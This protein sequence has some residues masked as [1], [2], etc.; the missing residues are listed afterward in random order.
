MFKNTLIKTKI[1]FLVG[2]AI[3]LSS[4][5]AELI[6]IYSIK[7]V[8]KQRIEKYRVDAYKEAKSN[9]EK[10]SAI[11]LSVVNYYYNQSDKDRM[12]DA[13]KDY[14]DEQSDYLF[15]ILQGEYDKYKGNM[16]DKKLKSLLMDIVKNARYGENGY[17]WINDF[18]YK[19]VMHPIKEK[20]TGKTFINTPKVPFVQLGVDKLKENSDDR[21]YIQYSFYSPSA[22]KYMHKASIVR[23]FKPYSWI[24]GTGAYIDSVSN[25]MKQKALESIKQM[26]YGNN[27]YFWVNDMTNRMLMHPIKPELDD[28]IFIDAPK[29]PFVELGVRKLRESKKDR[30]FIEYSFYT[31]S[32]KKYS[33]KLSAVTHFKPWG[34]VV[35]TGVY[36]DYIEKEIVLLKTETKNQVKSMIRNIVLITIALFVLLTLL[37]SYL[38][39]KIITKPLKKFQT[40][41]ESFFGYLSNPNK[42]ITYI[43]INSLDEFGKM[44]K[45][46]NKSIKASLEKQL[47]V[48]NIIKTI[49]KTVIITETD[50]KGIITY[51]SE[52]FCKI[53]GFTKE[54]LLGQPHYVV[55]HPDMPRKVFTDMWKTIEEKKIWKGNIKN[56]HKGGGFYWLETIITPKLTKEGEIYGYISVRCDITAKKEL[57][58]LK[59]R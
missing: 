4:F 12:K 24:I 5:L 22:K 35:G 9:L 42:K 16:S 49:D 40:S 19:M 32:T 20:L 26:R 52:E 59:K 58:E 48:S 46:V 50:K 45:E 14:I 37:A 2:M 13:V 18:N 56:V 53:S 17:F 55:R 15:T 54:E 38:S 6:S 44:S 51:V 47:E 33:H 31:P 39:D 27:G 7:K 23:V 30:D 25:E 3:L 36:T 43:D 11:A 41:L 21:D 1:V 10:Y 34:W 57:E 29:V 28:R 8:S